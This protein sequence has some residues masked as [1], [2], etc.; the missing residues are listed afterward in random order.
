MV[1]TTIDDSIKNTLKGQTIQ[2]I[3]VNAGFSDRLKSVSRLDTLNKAKKTKPISRDSMLDKFPLHSGSYVGGKIGQYVPFYSQDRTI[4]DKYGLGDVRPLIKTK[5]N[6]N[7]LRFQDGRSTA[8][9]NA[10]RAGM[11]ER[12]K[13]I[14]KK[15]VYFNRY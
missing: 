9:I 12:G 15:K 3:P 4:I 14:M 11:V 8:G 7:N 1:N 5:M 13:K 6:V 10:T 2:P